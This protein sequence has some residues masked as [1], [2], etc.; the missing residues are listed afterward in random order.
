MYIFFSFICKCQLIYTSR[1]DM[2]LL[3]GGSRR[4]MLW[5]LLSNPMIRTDFALYSMS[6][7]I[8]RALSLYFPHSESE[9]KGQCSISVAR[10]V[11]HNM[12][13]WGRQALRNE[14]W[15]LPCC[16]W[17]STQEQN[18]H[19]WFRCRWLRMLWLL[20]F[21]SIIRMDFA[22]FIRFLGS[23]NCDDSGGFFKYFLMFT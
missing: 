10:Q 21:N 19:S 9:E 12:L 5:S 4:M 15:R 13:K 3:V 6:G 7:R 2:K 11:C 14:V 18:V 20:L 23:G 16:T 8:L 1:R 17:M 22:L